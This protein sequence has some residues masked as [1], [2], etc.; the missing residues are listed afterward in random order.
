MTTMAAAALRFSLLVLFLLR[1][2]LAQWHVGPES[3]RIQFSG[4]EWIVKDSGAKRVEPGGNY[5]SSDAVRVGADGLK[6]RVFEK[7]GRFFCPEIVSAAN[8]GYGTYRVEI[9]SNVEGLAPNLTLGLFTWSDEAGEEGTH[10]EI[11]IEVGRWGNAKFN[12]DGT[13]N[14]NSENVQFVVQPF[15]R[16]EN[17]VRFPLP[18]DAP[19]SVHA[20]TWSYRQVHFMTSVRG[21][22]V[23][24][25][26]ITH[27]VPEP[28]NQNFRINL[29]IA[30]GHL[31]AVGI[32]EVTIRKFEFEPE[33]K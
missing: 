4:Y 18:A 19:E 9:S 22:L 21:A 26:V 14:S 6:L 23:Q 17:I 3:P 12:A 31:P 8:F 27:R 5:F 28:D 33:R 11:D 20:F 29:W 7:D 13:R 1:P 16:P 24:D 10:K 15:A 30:V 2:A 25:R 32:R